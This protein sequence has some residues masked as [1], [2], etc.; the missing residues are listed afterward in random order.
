M[1]LSIPLVLVARAFGAAKGPPPDAAYDPLPAGPAH[2]PAA[3]PALCHT[4]L[5]WRSW[6]GVHGGEG[7]RDD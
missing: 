6:D 5:G 3:P 7:R 1:A 4:S 2:A